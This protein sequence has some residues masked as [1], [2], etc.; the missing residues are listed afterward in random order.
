MPVPEPASGMRPA[1]VSAAPAL[2]LLDDIADQGAEAEPTVGARLGLAPARMGGSDVTC[3]WWPAL[4]RPADG[5]G[6][7][8]RGADGRRRPQ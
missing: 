1:Q 4:P 5:V 2:R 7:A 3:R 6:T 8:N